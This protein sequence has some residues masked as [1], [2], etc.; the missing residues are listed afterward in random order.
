MTVRDKHLKKNR[1]RSHPCVGFFVGRYL[2][3]QPGPNVACE[4]RMYQPIQKRNA[5]KFDVLCFVGKQRPLLLFLWTNLQGREIPT[6]PVGLGLTDA[7]GH[8]SASLDPSLH[9]WP[10]ASDAGGGG[11]VWIYVNAA[12]QASILIEVFQ[13]IPK[14]KKTKWASILIALWLLVG[15]ILDAPPNNTEDVHLW[16]LNR[17]S[18]NSV[19]MSILILRFQLLDSDSTGR[20]HQSGWWCLVTN[21]D[22]PISGSLVN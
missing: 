13:S 11:K 7:S 10:L 21:I 17:K 5:Q 1:G 16:E 2:E 19:W 6:S 15:W 14:Q 12:C 9:F 4:Q 20:V 8:H 22:Y 18:T 3:N